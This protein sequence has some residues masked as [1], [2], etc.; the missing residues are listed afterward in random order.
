MNT[1]SK[2]CKL[3]DVNKLNLLK[4]NYNKQPFLVFLSLNN[5]Y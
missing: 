2:I 1:I 3:F 5:N 4:I